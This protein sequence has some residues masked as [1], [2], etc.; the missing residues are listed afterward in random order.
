[1]N[2]KEIQNKVQE[3]LKQGNWKLVVF[4]HD[5]EASISFKSDWLNMLDVEVKIVYTVETEEHFN[6]CRFNGMSFK[7]DLSEVKIQILETVIEY[8][9]TEHVIDLEAFS[10]TF[11]EIIAEYHNPHE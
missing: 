7:E 8:N 3:E 2:L 4:S 11:A 5:K 9:G 6:W 1:M 10:D